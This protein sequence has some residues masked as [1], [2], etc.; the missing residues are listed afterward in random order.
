MIPH[1]GIRRVVPAS[2]GGRVG[3]RRPGTPKRGDGAPA[4]SAEG[5]SPSG[6]VLCALEKLAPEDADSAGGLD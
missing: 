2:F 1:R 6:G 4:G 5:E 3:R